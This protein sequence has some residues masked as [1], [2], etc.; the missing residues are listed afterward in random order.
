MVFFP[1]TPISKD[2]E[3]NRVTDVRVAPNNITVVVAEGVAYIPPQVVYEFNHSLQLVNVMLSDDIQ[4]RYALMQKS[5]E[6][7]V[8]A[9][10]L[11][12]ER[13]KGQVKII[14]YNS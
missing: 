11:I 13:L 5:G 3:F 2:Q 8:E 1:R 4:Q 7:P 12:A 14:H 6:L 9:P 10:E